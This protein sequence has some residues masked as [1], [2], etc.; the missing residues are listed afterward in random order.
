LGKKKE[1][2]QQPPSMEG[3]T[4]SASEHTT[5][6]S[7]QHWVQIQYLNSSRLKRVARA[8]RLTWLVGNC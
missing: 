2:A 8:S 6:T 3:Q 1:Q 5:S 4:Q 7:H